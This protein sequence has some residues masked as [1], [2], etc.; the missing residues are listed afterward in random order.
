MKRA[1]LILA[2]GSPRRHILLRR[3]GIAFRVVTSGVEEVAAEGEAG[4]SYASRMAREKALRVSIDNP[5]AV[6]LAAD[7][8]V[9]CDGEI[10]EKPRDPADAARMLRMLSGNVHTVVT[11]YAIARAGALLQSEQVFSSVRFRELGQDEIQ[12]YIETG[13]PFD[14]AGAYGIQDK[15]ASFIAEVQGSRDN[16]MGLPLTQVVAA[17]ARHGIKP[18]M[19]QTE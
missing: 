8:V 13:A 17:L 7:T 18:L 16:V 14:K 12:R 2:S 3:A 15:G 11:A 6:V 5:E 19:G 9:L 4:D 1:E 10:L